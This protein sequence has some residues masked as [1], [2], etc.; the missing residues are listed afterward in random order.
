MVEMMVVMM[1][2][3]L[4]KLMVAR[5]A[6]MMV[7][8]TAVRKG[9]WMVVMMVLMVVMMAVMMVLMMVLMMV[10]MTV[11]RLVVMMDL[12]LHYMMVY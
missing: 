7:D 3:D 12:L 11:W 6:V 10:D 4:D 1:V 2:V 9:D 5:M 8:K